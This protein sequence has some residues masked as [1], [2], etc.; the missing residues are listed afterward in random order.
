ERR[1]RKPLSLSQGDNDLLA[2]LARFGGGQGDIDDPYRSLFETPSQQAAGAVRA[3]QD[4]E[5]KERA[6]PEPLIRGDF[7]AIQARLLGAE[8][9]EDEMNSSPNIVLD[10]RDEVEGEA[11]LA[12]PEPY[13]EDANEGSA[14]YEA[15]RSRRPLYV[16]TAMIVAGVAGIFASF[17]LKGAVS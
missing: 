13:S 5:A 2:E 12:Y 16:M 7:A 8:L 11:H 4:G 10:H 9:P 14:S 3:G 1:L 6:K 15:I 17:A